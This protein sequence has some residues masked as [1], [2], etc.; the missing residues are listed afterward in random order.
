LPQRPV[1]PLVLAGP[2]SYGFV[3]LPTCGATS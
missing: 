2:T 3:P 1:A